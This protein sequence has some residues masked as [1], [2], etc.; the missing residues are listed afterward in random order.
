MFCTLSYDSSVDLW[1]VGV[2]LYGKF[3]LF[4]LEV[5]VYSHIPQVLYCA[6]ITSYVLCGNQRLFASYAML[7]RPRNLKTAAN[8]I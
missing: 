7:M 1:S 2:I 5:D 8:K 3:V 6:F 4:I